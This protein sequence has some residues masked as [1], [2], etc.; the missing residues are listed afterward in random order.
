MWV[1][2]IF[3]VQQ[4]GNGL[5]IGGIGSTYIYFTFGYNGGLY[6]LFTTV[7]MI[8]TAFCPGREP[9]PGIGIGT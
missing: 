7:G 3:L 9:V 8:P 6:S 5:V 1:A 2:V 4:V